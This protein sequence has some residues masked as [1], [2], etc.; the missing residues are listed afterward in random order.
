M[1]GPRRA[2]VDTLEIAFSGLAIGG[3][4]IDAIG[5]DRSGQSRVLAPGAS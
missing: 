2:C 1:K 5:F 3:A 4:G